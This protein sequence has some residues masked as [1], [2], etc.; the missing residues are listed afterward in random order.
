MRE[1]ETAMTQKGQ[2]TIPVEIRRALGLNPRDRV[3][4]EIDRERGVATLRPAPSVVQG[5]LGAVEA[6]EDLLDSS[7]D[8]ATLEESIASE[9]MSE[10]A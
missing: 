2:V 5:L 4:F 3:L 6:A 8:R 9:V 1:N 10:T 7:A